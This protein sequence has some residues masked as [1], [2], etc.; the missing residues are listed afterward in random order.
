MLHGFGANLFTWTKIR[1][2]L[3]VRN[4]IFAVDLK[5]F[6]DSPKP[7]DGAYGLHDQAASVLRLIERR[8]FED[9]T[10]VGHS[11]GGGVA[12]MVALE[13]QRREPARRRRLVLIGSIGVPQ[14]MP[15]FM[16][17]L[18]VPLLGE[19]MVNTV[20]PRRLVRHVLRACYFDR[21]RIENIFVEA[22]A[23]PPGSR[24]GRMAL[25]ASVRQ[26]VPADVA[27]LIRRYS[28]IRVP[29]LLLWGREDRIV[30]LALGQALAAAIPGARLVV[31]DR[32][33]HIPQ[34]ERAE[35]TFA[36][37]RDAL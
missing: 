10:I 35:A 8:G 30:P 19:L 29:V 14:R 22:Y 24:A 3:S 20:P 1:A 17:M 27:S 28:E 6:G 11:M 34:E 32:C 15:R 33:G 23:R 2:L 9:V 5:G 16:A 13:L 21:S 7:D 25:L 12:L 18:L 4:T 37:L 36:V 26:M 31:L